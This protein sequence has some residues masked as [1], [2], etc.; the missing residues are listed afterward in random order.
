MDR[1][2]RKRSLGIIVRRSDWRESSRIVTLCT[3]D[4]GVVSALAK[5]AHRPKSPFLGAIDLLHIVDAKLGIHPLRSLQRL[6]SAD[7]I[8][9]NRPFRHQRERR[10][11]AL[12]LTKNILLA[13][14]EG[15]PDSS[16][17]DLFRGGLRLLGAAPEPKLKIVR[18]GLDLRYLELLGVLPPPDFC[19]LCEKELPQQGKVGFLP[20]AGGFIHQHEG[21][22]PISATLP[23]FAKDLLATPG[24]NLPGFRA[25]DP[26]VQDL[27]TLIQELISNL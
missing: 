19:P 16:L 1:P 4:F 8:Q 14:P 25:P 18:L 26:M 12:Q 20:R 3:R 11:L 24:R 22:R 21:G 2:Q 7:V 27:S 13:M 17:F 9:G 10:D 5:G 15:R 23:R 6:Y